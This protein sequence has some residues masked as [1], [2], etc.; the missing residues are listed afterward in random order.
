MQVWFY[1]TQTSVCANLSLSLCAA[2]PSTQYTSNFFTLL[3]L[4]RNVWM[5][6][7]NSGFPPFS[8]LASSRYL[9][10]AAGWDRWEGGVVTQRLIS[11]VILSSDNLLTG[12]VF[13]PSY[14][15]PPAMF[16]FPIH[17][18]CLQINKG[19]GA[20]SRHKYVSLLY[21]GLKIS[22]R[23]LEHIYWR[24]LRLESWSLDRSWWGL[25]TSVPLPH[26]SQLMNHYDWYLK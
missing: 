5:F 7:R 13:H 1:G 19:S 25:I 15:P 14:I 6:S 26:S 11:C 24:F 4:I 12:L 23:V 18:A 17:R 8:S 3:W 9:L 2:I 10:L 21:V 22:T 20:E 16:V